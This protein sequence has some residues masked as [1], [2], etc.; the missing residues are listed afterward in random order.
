MKICSFH[1][2]LFAIVFFAQG[3][4]AAPWIVERGQARAE[5]VIAEEPTRSARLGATELQTYL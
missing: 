4:A 5:I 3:L 2:F 1:R